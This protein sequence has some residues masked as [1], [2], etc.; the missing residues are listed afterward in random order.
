[1]CQGFKTSTPSRV[2]LNWI[3]FL[4]LTVLRNYSEQFFFVC[5]FFL[6]LEL[7]SSVEIVPLKSVDNVF[8]GLSREV[9]ILIIKRDKWLYF[10]A[11]SINKIAIVSIRSVFWVW[12][13]SVRA[14]VLKPEQNKI[15][16]SAWLDS[17]RSKLEKWLL[18]FWWTSP[19]IVLKLLKYN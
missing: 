8:C 13:T 17:T 3:L 12:G 19:W 10:G 1:M 16:L 4:V 7:F 14:D 6:Y 15:K 9:R 2:E 5:L 11:R 18:H